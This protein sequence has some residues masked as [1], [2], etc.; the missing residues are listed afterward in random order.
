MGEVEREVTYGENVFA[1]V[2]KLVKRV[3]VSKSHEAEEAK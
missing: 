2:R 3:R 1:N